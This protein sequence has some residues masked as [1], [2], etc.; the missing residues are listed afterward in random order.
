MNNTQSADKFLSL[1]NIVLGTLTGLLMSGPALSETQ[2]PLMNMLMT[3]LFITLG[4][5]IG[6]KRRRS[7]G[8]LYLSLIC[9]LVLS[10]LMLRAFIQIQQ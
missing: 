6:Y 8:F 3:V 5:I 10:S 7:R 9:V 2:S 4:T 1:A